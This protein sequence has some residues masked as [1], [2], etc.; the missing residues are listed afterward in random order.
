MF[1]YKQF[2]SA[3]CLFL[4]FMIM[5]RAKKNQFDFLFFLL[6]FIF[7]KKVF[8]S[9]IFE[10]RQFRAFMILGFFSC[11]GLYNFLNDLLHDNSN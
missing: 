11:L 5:L 8:F 3:V 9:E 10:C 1:V 7:Q 2:K 6:Q 4:F